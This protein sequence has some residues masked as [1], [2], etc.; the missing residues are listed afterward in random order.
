MNIS[1]DHN[2]DYK[3]VEQWRNCANARVWSDGGRCHRCCRFIQRQT[4]SPSHYAYTL[5]SSECCT[6]YTPVLTQT[7]QACIHMCA[8]A[9]QLSTYSHSRPEHMLCTYSV[10]EMHTFGATHVYLTNVR[11]QRAA[12][13]I[14]AAVAVAAAACGLRS[15]SCVNIMESLVVLSSEALVA[16]HG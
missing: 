1:I 7:S 9:S 12:R 6:R 15:W 16:I 3:P 5:W 11:C 10:C 14:E 2:A 4:R 13:P 8:A